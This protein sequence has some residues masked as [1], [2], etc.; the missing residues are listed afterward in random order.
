MKKAS[1]VQLHDGFFLPSGTGGQVGN[2]L[3]PANKTLDNLDLY[4]LDSGQ[5][6]MEWTAKGSKHRYVIG[7]AAVKGVLLTPDDPKTAKPKA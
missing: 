2:T 6:Q 7:A 1:F 5:V 3:P 4:L